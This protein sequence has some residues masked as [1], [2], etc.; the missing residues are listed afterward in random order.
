MNKLSCIYYFCFKVFPSKVHNMKK[1]N[2]QIL[3]FRNLQYPF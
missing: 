1:I 3:I 2:C